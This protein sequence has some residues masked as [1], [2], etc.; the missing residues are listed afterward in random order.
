MEFWS[1]FYG[2]AEHPHNRIREIRSMYHLLKKNLSTAVS[3]QLHLFILC[4][5]Y[6]QCFKLFS[7][8][9]SLQ[10]NIFI[11]CIL[12]N[13]LQCKMI[14]FLI[15]CKVSMALK[16]SFLQLS[17]FLNIAAYISGNNRSVLWH[18][19]TLWLRSQGH[20]AMTRY[21]MAERP[22]QIEMIHSTGSHIYRI[23]QA[24][25]EEPIWIAV[26]ANHS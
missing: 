24:R 9:L 1:F 2:T 26:L 11:L 8:F 5:A 23:D 20:N 4:I 18:V 25:V 15:L 14:H 17:S 13:V 7:S 6:L 12:C 21:S 22:W 16:I 10:P 19:P 3:L